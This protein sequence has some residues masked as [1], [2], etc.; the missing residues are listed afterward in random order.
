MGFLAIILWQ[1]DSK[2]SRGAT[3]KL[4]D[5]MRAP[6]ER[7]VASEGDRP[8]REDEAGLVGKARVANSSRMQATRVDIRTILMK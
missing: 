1:T 4:R 8:G 7:L 3:I 2:T 5:I 6:I